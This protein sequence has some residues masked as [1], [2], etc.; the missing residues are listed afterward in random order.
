MNIY[1]RNSILL[2]LITAAGLD[3]AHGWTYASGT[4]VGKCSNLDETGTTTDFAMNSII[5]KTLF[6]DPGV[7]D[8]LKMAFVMPSDTS[9]HADI[10][11]VE[12]FGNVKYYSAAEK[13]YKLIGAIPGV[14]KLGEDGLVGVAVERPFKNR[15]YLVYSHAANAGIGSTTINGTFR[16]SRFSMDPASR[17]LDPGSE[18]VLLDVPSSRGRWHTSGALQSDNAGNIYWAVGDNETAFSGPANTH[19]LRGSI[20]R[21]HPNE[22]GTGYTIPAGNFAEVWANK[23]SG[24]GRTALAAKYRDT[25]KVKPEIFIKGL[26][27][28]Y[29]IQVD[30]HRQ[31]VVYGQCGPDYGGNSE[32]HSNSLTPVFA[33]WPFWSG[34]TKVAASQVGAAQYG[35][36]N[37]AEPTEATWANFLPADQANPVNSWTGSMAGEPGPGVDTLPAAVAAKYTYARSC[38]MGS[39]IV[40]YDGRIS[41]P[42]KMPPQM[43][44]VWLMGDYNTRKLRAVKVDANGNTVGTVN[45]N[46]G[47]FTNGTGTPNGVGAITDLQQGPDGALYALN[48]NCVG[49]TLSGE[50]NHYGD[51]CSG[52]LRIEYK[53][54]ACSD[55]ALYPKQGTTRVRESAP[56]YRNAR[57]EVDWM[58]L[59]AVKF[60]IFAAGK[61]SAKIMD[62]QGRLLASMQGEGPKDYALP[63]SLASNHIY[64]LE[65]KTI[66]GM[67]VRAFLR[68]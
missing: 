36:N 53:G 6:P 41:N 52:I 10:I 51:A 23:F 54:E 28:T 5:N 2:L 67:L 35:K 37:S 57:A 30:P 39:M 62:S 31:Q 20:V 48:F 12:R 50:G 40:H 4:A 8:I 43:D 59:G 1:K 27:N 11:T 15:V 33:G 13:T 17:M 61:H 29:A 56:S 18:K 60:S 38:A 64:F 21:I 45:V 16:L 49:G 3:I 9:T 46:A 42:A 24:Q 44:N 47:I 25:S 32:V 34:T 65:V 7:E 22:D 58:H 26:R 63:E 14:S 19:D 66:R 68:P 55:T